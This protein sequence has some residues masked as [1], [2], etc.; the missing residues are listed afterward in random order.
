MVIIL[1]EPGSL[2][3]IAKYV[4]ESNQHSGDKH[5][6]KANKLFGKQ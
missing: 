3:Q 2:E 1:S 6:D 4:E 5:N